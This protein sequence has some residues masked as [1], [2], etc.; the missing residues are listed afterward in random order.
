MFCKGV[1]ISATEN[2]V[3]VSDDFVVEC[4]AGGMISVRADTTNCIVEAFDA[5][6]FVVILLQAEP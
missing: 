6:R 2:D 1:T 5:A 4:S 3:I